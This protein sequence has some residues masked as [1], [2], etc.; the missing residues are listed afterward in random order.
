M[1]GAIDGI[2]MAGLVLSDPV[3]PS[4][5][6]EHAE[7]IITEY[8]S[9]RVISGEPRCPRG[10]CGNGRAAV[11]DGGT[12]RTRGTEARHRAGQL[13]PGRDP[14]PPRRLRDRIRVALASNTR[15]PQSRRA[16]F[17]S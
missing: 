4:A 16:G 14:V 8:E 17:R 9:I 10:H 11:V 6:G 12:A 5:V 2:L 7:I 13:E 1:A 15:R 3:V